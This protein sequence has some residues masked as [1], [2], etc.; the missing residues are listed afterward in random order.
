VPIFS[1]GAYF[2]RFWHYR[3]VPGTG[4]EFKQKKHEN[5]KFY[6][7]KNKE[8]FNIEDGRNNTANISFKNDNDTNSLPQ[9]HCHRRKKCRLSFQCE[10]DLP[11]S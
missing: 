7:H 11:L 4:K 9:Q 2:S 5:E 10:D 6:L 1:L 3:P 8:I